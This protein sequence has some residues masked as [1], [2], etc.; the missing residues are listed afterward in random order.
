MGWIFCNRGA[1]IWGTL[2]RCR[3]ANLLGAWMMISREDLERIL[4]RVFVIATLSLAG[5]FCVVYLSDYLSVRYRIPG[6]REQFGTVT[7]QRYDAVQE[8]SGKTE[9]IFNPP[10]AQTCVRALFPHFGYPPCWYLKRHTEPR[11]DI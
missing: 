9:F 7:V 4:R 2:V 3:I 6:N 8:K 5:L 1:G 11:T 10:A